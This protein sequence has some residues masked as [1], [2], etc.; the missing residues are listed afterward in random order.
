M[1]HKTKQRNKECE[2]V[3]LKA[4]SSA[5]CN[6]SRQADSFDG[7]IMMI[8]IIPL[9]IR[10]FMFMSFLGIGRLYTIFYFELIHMHNILTIIPKVMCIH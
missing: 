4:Q 5:A 6:D 7:H 10:I 3:F 2:A 8:T 9:H 1:L